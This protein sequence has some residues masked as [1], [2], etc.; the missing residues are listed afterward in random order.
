M[1]DREPELQFVLKVASRCNLNCSYCYVYN[2]GDS[3]WRTRPAF[4]R[5]DVVTAA[6]ERIRRHV[7]L[8]GQ[9]TVRI[10]FHGGEPLLAGP[11]RFSRWCTRLHD[12]LA[13]VA[14]V[15]L[16]VQTNGTVLDEDW[17]EVLRRHQVDVGISIDG[18]PEIHDR[19]RVDHRGRGSHH[20]VER[21]IA[22]MHAEGAPVNLLSVIPFGVDPLLVHRHFVSLGAASVNYLLPDYTHDTIAPV[23][24]RYGP[25][26]CADFLL[27]VFDEW[28]ANNDIDLKIPLFWTIAR[29]VLGGESRLD[30]LGNR[31]FRF[32]FVEADGDVEGLD[33]LRV[34]EGG[35]YRTGLN[36]LTHDFRDIAAASDLHRA[37]MFDGVPLPTGCRACPERRTCAGGY[38]PHR[39]SRERGF[40]NPSVWC[41][42]ILALFA[43]IRAKLGVDVE[44]TTRRRSELGLVPASTAA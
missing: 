26:P 13:D 9:G 7:A 19:Y 36:V 8:S 43:H 23:R 17:I 20:K 14:H 15:R 40:D 3:S 44:E 11:R 5:E 10:T 16:A 27:P 2:K 35:V 30:L 37:A 29:L 42:D 18:P 38:L 12:E 32:V 31:P 41:A 4:I 24:E 22:L 34:C 1:E 33:V 39:F 25:T 21:A 28:W 6:I